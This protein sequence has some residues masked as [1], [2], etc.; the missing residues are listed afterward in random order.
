MRIR[1][2]VQPRS[3]VFWVCTYLKQAFVGPSSFPLH[4]SFFVSHLCKKMRLFPACGK[5]LECP[6][7]TDPGE[8]WSKWVCWLMRTLFLFLLLVCSMVWVEKLL[9]QLICPFT[10][11]KG[12]PS[13]E[14]FWLFKGQREAC[15]CGS[16]EVPRVINIEGARL[17]CVRIDGGAWRW[18]WRVWL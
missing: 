8:L 16:W 4:L 10:F 6:Y 2:G 9:S 11:C 12:F 17:M 3:P 14:K 13:Q 5:G 1:L 18:T 15:M 7:H